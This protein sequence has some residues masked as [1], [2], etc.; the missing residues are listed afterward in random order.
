MKIWKY[1]LQ[2]EDEQTIKMP[3]GAKV[4]S[5]QMQ[6]DEI[7]VWALVDPAAELENKA[8]WIIGTG[9]PFYLDMNFAK[10]IGTVQQ[11]GGRLVWHIFE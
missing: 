11:L 5:V 10:Y 3:K 6:N 2:M 1:V 4:L 8:F 9:N 7:C